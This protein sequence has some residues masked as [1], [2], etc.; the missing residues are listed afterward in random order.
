MLS[1]TG[2]ALVCMYC[3][4][5]KMAPMAQTMMPKY[6]SDKPLAPPKPGNFTWLK[7]G[8]LISDSLAKAL[9]EQPKAAN[10]RTTQ[11]HSLLFRIKFKR[12]RLLPKNPPVCQQE[13]LQRASLL[14]QV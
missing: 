11:N 7:S 8:I 13:N 1:C 10:T 5:P 12:G 3:T 6:M 4:K 2:S 9:V 14:S